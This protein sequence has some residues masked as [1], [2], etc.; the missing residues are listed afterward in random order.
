M[1]NK[2]YEEKPHQ[3]CTSK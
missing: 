2:K 1:R 3:S